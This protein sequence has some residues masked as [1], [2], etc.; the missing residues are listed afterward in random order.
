MA[1]ETFTLGV[2]FAGRGPG[3]LDGTGGSGA[4]SRRDG[5]E[6]E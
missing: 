5:K 6:D 3:E 2:L 4:S 1:G